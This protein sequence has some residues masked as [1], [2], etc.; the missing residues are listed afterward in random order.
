MDNYSGFNDFKKILK[1][2]LIYHK[3]YVIIKVRR[4]KYDELCFKL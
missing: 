3:K 2:L 4:V 1:S